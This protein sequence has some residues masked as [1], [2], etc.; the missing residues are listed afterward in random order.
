MAGQWTATLAVGV[1]L[2]L[3]LTCLASWLGYQAHRGSQLA[4][5][6]ADFVEVASQGALNLA[7]I[8]SATVEDDVK[9]VVDA[10]INPFLNDFQQRSASFIDFVVQ[11]N[12]S[13]EATI[14]EVALESAESD[15]A[16]VMVA[17]SVQVAAE[18]EPQD[19]A[20][21]HWRMR[22]TVQKDPGGS[23]K[24]SNVEFVP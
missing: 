22:V 7:N 23:V 9:R 13:S 18:G 14:R 4:H 16:Q 8:G 2:A 3:V 1:V 17:L 11:A 12:S 15:W 19:S 21:R 24:M 5:N 6:E 10:S 20:A